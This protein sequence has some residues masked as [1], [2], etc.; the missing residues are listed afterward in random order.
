MCGTTG[1]RA[2]T[3]IKTLI[4]LEIRN[5][6][7]SGAIQQSIETSRG[8]LGK[9]K[10]ESLHEEDVKLLPDE[11]VEFR[12]PSFFQLILKYE[13]ALVASLADKLCEE[14]LLPSRV[15]LKR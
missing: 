13:T 5:H 6:F 7:A 8:R 2:A 1:W 10:F 3:P 14:I 15:R 12:N 9:W 11:R 4:E